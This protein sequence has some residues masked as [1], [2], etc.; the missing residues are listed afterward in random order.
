[1]LQLLYLTVEFAVV[2]A[3]LLGAYRLRSLL[4][5][6]AVV[7]VVASMQ[8]LQAIV[9]ASY[10]WQL[11]G[12]VYSPGS[13][14]FFV[15]NLAIVL[16]AFARDGA[17]PTRNLVYAVLI[18]NAVPTIL[19]SL[20]Q[21]HLHAFPPLGA[22]ELY[23]GLFETAGVAALVG[24]GLLYLD[25]LVAVLSFTWLRNISRLPDGVIY[26]I[27]LLLAA[28]L[29]TVGFLGVL[30]ALSPDV[31]EM[32]ANGLV[33]KSLGALAFGVVWGSLLHGMSRVERGTVRQ[34]F[35][36]L[37]FQ[38]DVAELK[39]A[40]TRDSLTGVLNRRS[41][42]KAIG[43]T[44][45]ESTGVEAGDGATSALVLVD[46]DHFK[47]VN[48][49]L[50]HAAG[51]EVLVAIAEWLKESARSG[52][53][54]FRIGGDEFAVLLHEC[55]KMGARSFVRRAGRFGWRHE[56]LEEPVTLSMGVA[57]YPADGTSPDELF[58]VADRRLYDAKAAGRATAS[59]P[60][61]SVTAGPTDKDDG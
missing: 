13:C 10:Y 30:F 31:W 58:E 24:V 18:G 32:L 38:E 5:L 11:G 52:D 28:V 4:G 41:F 60:W 26:A 34:V 3:L 55:D 19:A 2:T 20:I 50:G 23:G 44:C 39:R 51:D 57:V 48:D 47:R 42:D 29:D 7:A 59:G 40:A 61:P 54:V 49:V 53:R 21:W 17:V 45:Q 25:Q 8:L 1:M 43:A 27:S 46:V 12:V 15:G 9:G 16:W 22:S 36:T 37:L 35:G 14:V 33:S 56:A 6:S